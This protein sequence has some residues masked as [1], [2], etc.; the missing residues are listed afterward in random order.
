MQM[1]LNDWPFVCLDFQRIVKTFK[2][3][4]KY[5]NHCFS[6][7][8]EFLR[9]VLLYMYF[10][11]SLIDNWSIKLAI[12]SGLS[13]LIQYF[14]CFPLILSCDHCRFRARFHVRKCSRNQPKSNKDDGTASC[15]SRLC[16][17]LSPCCG[18]VEIG[19]RVILPPDFSRLLHY[20]LRFR[21]GTG[22]VNYEYSTVQ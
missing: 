13:K 2:A 17:R 11:K 1:P 8:I 20:I 10:W 18:T 21:W 9:W 5:M 4:T 16:V 3:I 19:E 6:F 14:R 22:R 7:T 12:N 15:L